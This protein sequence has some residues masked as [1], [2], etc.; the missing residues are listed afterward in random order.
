MLKKSVLGLKAYHKKTWS[1]E[2][3]LMMKGFFH[4]HTLQTSPV[5]CTNN[6]LPS[7]FFHRHKNLQ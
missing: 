7:G 3:P 2:D 6:I 1:S 4:H 5:D